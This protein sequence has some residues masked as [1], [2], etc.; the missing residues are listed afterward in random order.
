MVV[1]PGT[2]GFFGGI[3]TMDIGRDKLKIHA[4]HM[5]EFIEPGWSFVIELLEN[6][7][8]AA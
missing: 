1:F 5:H 3:G 4:L 7:S 8:E 6:G 2:D